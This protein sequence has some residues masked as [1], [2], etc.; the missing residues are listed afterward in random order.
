[1][2]YAEYAAIDGLNW[3]RLKPILTSPAHYRAALTTPRTDTA[4]MML[5][6]V[7]H[8][9]VLEPDTEHD[10]M[11]WDGGSRGTKAGK[12]AWSEW[13]TARGMDPGLRASDVATL[14]PADLDIARR[15]RDAVW[16]HRDA[17]AILD[18]ASTEVTLQRDSLKGRADILRAD[19]VWDLKTART[20]DLRAFQRA[21][22]YM[23]Y[24]EQLAFY[25]RLAGVPHAGIIAVE[26]TAPYDVL[27][28]E[29][30][31]ATMARA[32]ERVQEALDLLAECERTG[33]WPGRYPERMTLEGP[34][35][36]FPADEID[37]FTFAEDS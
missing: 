16:A 20:V 1:M 31:P 24:Y 34:G 13:L 22:V 15:C 29:I 26:T 32:D 35:W 33:L 2:T 6:R 18:E 10:A 14:T 5:G 23:L 36:Y 4:A 9:Y 27:V 30:G 28:M 8:S 21:C 3:S 12:A 37:D 19:S 11:V 25:R 7:V 17:A